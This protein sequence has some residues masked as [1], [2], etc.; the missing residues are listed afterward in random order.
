[1]AA[2]DP[3]ADIPIFRQTRL[4]NWRVIS[5]IF[6]IPSLS[7]CFDPNAPIETEAGNLTQAQVNAIISDCGGAPG[8][9][10]VEDG[11]ITIEKSSDLAVTGCVLDALHATGET[12]LT[13]VGNQR[14]ETSER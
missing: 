11:L 12:G 3:I 5:L 2:N 7:G 9:V 13:S 1:M 10:R 6:C 8:M 14:Y 4:M